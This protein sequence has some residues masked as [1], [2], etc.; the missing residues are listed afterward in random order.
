MKLQIRCI[1]DNQTGYGLFGTSVVMELIRRGVDLEVYPIFGNYFTHDQSPRPQEVLDRI[2]PVERIGSESVLIY[3]LV[4]VPKE[5]VYF[6]GMSYFT[7]WE[8]TR[9]QKIAVDR[10]NNCRVVIVPGGWNATVLS[11]CGVYSPIRIVPLGTDVDV[12]KPTW[13][14]CL[15]SNVFQ[16]CS[17][18]RYGGGGIR[19]R[20]DLVVQAFKMAFPTEPDVRLSMKAF[21]DCPIQPDPDPRITVNKTFWT[22]PKMAE[23][24]QSSDVF[25]SASACEGWGLHQHE[26]MCCGRPVIS[27]NFGG[28]TEF[29]N[30]TNGYPVRYNLRAA[31][32]VYEGKG[33][34]AD[35]DVNSLAAQMRLAYSDRSL[36]EQKSHLSAQSAR[37]FTIQH[38]VD[39]F[40]EV[41]R[42][43]SYL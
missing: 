4:I 12:F 31:E 29:W 24:Y 13:L 20:S 7:M 23:W 21:V 15:S 40:I 39:R 22:R 26:A 33:C 35:I 11:A 17:G 10:C 9:V 5:I 32:G 25:V 27:A 2:V 43:F 3:G 19:K 18:A 42:E 37:R 38:C 28:V 16:F 6:N 30:D 34:Y 8:T 1:L 36:L 14:P 41:M